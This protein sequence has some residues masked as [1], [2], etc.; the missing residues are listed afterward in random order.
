MKICQTL[1]AE[2][3]AL[4]VFDPAAIIQV[5]RVLSDSGVTYCSDAYEAVLGSDALVIATE[6]NE[7]RDLDLD[8]MR[9]GMRDGVLIDA[10]NIFDP[11]KAK[12]AGFRYYGMGRG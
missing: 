7:F 4:R 5:R 8:K 6:W 3:C 2:K 12:N 10:R 9:K 11:L 1:A